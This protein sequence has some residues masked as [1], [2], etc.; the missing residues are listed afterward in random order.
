[1]R[2]GQQGSAC[3]AG[4]GEAP[5]A[6]PAAGWSDAQPG[7]I[8][9]PNS[10]SLRAGPHHNLWSNLDL[11]KGSRPYASSGSAVRG[12]HA[13]RLN[14]WWNIHAS[15]ASKPTLALPECG[16]GALANFIG[17]YAAPPG[18]A[19]APRNVL[20]PGW[21]AAAPLGWYV[22][23]PAGGARAFSPPDLHQAMFFTR[24]QRLAATAKRV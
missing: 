3:G 4:V 18:A 6:R 24:W 21:C 16:Y 11:G 1:M 20:F 23:L 22:E 7:S 5:R 8:M 13:A 2:P 15:S 9:P 14:T 12:A 19:A 17:A 10:H